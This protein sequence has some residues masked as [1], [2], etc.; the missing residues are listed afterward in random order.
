MLIGLPRIKI[1]MRALI[2][3][4]IDA[5]FLLK[6]RVLYPKILSFYQGVGMEISP[7]QISYLYGLAKRRRGVLLDIGC[8]MGLSTSVLASTG[9]EVLSFDWFKG[10][11]NLTENDPD[12]IEGQCF[13]PDMKERFFENINRIGIAG[14]V[15]LVEGDCTKTTPSLIVS[16]EL[17]YF[18]LAFLDLDL[19][20]S[21]KKTI[22][23]LMKIAKGG[24]LILSHDYP[25]V[26]ICKAVEEAIKEYPIEV[27]RKYPILTLKVNNY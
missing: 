6:G 7:A 14:K 11:R 5:F 21:T 12:F 15:K 1:P 16:G 24:E 27:V 4:I 22:G 20:E 13:V 10:L 17:K 25:S 18:A 9:N 19:Y 2:N 3:K 26:G 8:H 23:N